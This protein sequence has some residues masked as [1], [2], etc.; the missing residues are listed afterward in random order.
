[1]KNL[2][3]YSILLVL[4][5]IATFLF[6]PTAQAL[7]DPKVEAEAVYLIDIST[8]QVLYSKNADQSID[9]DHLPY[10][11]TV[12][13]TIEAIDH[14]DISQYDAFVVPE[15]FDKELDDN[16]KRCGLIAGETVTV[17]SLLYC[18]LL[19]QADDACNV[20]A[21]AVAGSA[22]KFVEQMN[23]YAEKSGCTD[24]LFSSP[25]GHTSNQ[26]NTTAKD[27]ALFLEVA[28]SHPLFR[29]IATT[30][31]YDLP[32]T[33]KNSS[34][35]IVGDN[36][37]TSSL[38]PDYYPYASFSTASL[39]ETSIFATAVKDD[40]A[41]LAIVFDTDSGACYSTAAT[42]FDW[43]FQHFQYSDVL[44]TKDIITEE[45]ISM[46]SENKTVKLR[47]AQSIALL[48]PNKET[49]N[50]DLQ[51]TCYEKQLTAPISVGTVLGE[52]RVL[53]NGVIYGS[54]S[55]VAANAVS[56]SEKLFIRS[57]LLSTLLRPAVLIIVAVVLILLILYI[58]S[59]VR[60]R[61]RRRAY[62][63]YKNTMI[64]ADGE[65]KT[66]SAVIAEVSSDSPMTPETSKSEPL[67]AEFN[68]VPKR[69]LDDLNDLF[70]DL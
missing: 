9:S 33:D 31:V 2:K 21:Y 13:L 32:E 35:T 55:L 67:A 52:V 68:K 15:D 42:L 45:K 65:H 63:R 36:T 20:L 47:P 27:T 37:F 16:S 23:D 40:I 54:T 44:T 22:A 59:V 48:I 49:M 66:P 34:R 50:F 64:G 39:K 30:E 5:F 38:D 1:M 61:K 41:L 18:T 43:V 56:R 24:T 8:Q 11:A 58:L 26:H 4:C 6:V 51:Y 19:E 70:K 7:A 29:E 17:E 3:F 60:Y 10:I 62:L 53:H 57:Q 28:L 69:D 46:A 14:G 12:L 25:N